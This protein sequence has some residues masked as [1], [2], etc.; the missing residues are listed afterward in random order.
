MSGNS[1][2]L[3]SGYRVSTGNVS[4]KTKIFLIAGSRQAAN[5]AQEV[6]DQIKYWTARGYSKDEIACYYIPPLRAD[7][8]DKDQFGELFS[9][10]RDCYFAEPHSIYE[11][12]KSVAQYNPS[13]VYVYVSSH[14]SNPIAERKF[15]YKNKEEELNTQKIIKA[16]P[17]WMQT[18]SLEVEGYY[19]QK[20]TFWTYDN[21]SRAWAFAEKFPHDADNMMFTPGGLKKALASLPASTK[22]TVVLQ[23]CYT[24]GFILPAKKVGA[25]HTLE[26]LENTVVLTASRSDRTSFGCDSGAHTTYFGDAYLT[27][28]RKLPENQ[29]LNNIDWKKVFEDTQSQVSEKEAFFGRAKNDYSKPQ[30][31][32]N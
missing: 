3:N 23:G 11:N 32:Y 1:T 27:A 31:Y 5:F 30:Y 22:K 7:K 25:N 10:L 12:I 4:P 21:I 13:E 9:Q 28:L 20:N 18:Y 26:G 16:F 2:L 29:R 17:D 6:I 19:D 14:G 8:N 15:N 24:G